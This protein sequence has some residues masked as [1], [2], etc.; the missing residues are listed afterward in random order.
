MTTHARTRPPGPPPPAKHW[1]ERTDLTLDD[2][3]DLVQAD[4]FTEYDRL[5]LI[6]G[7]LVAMSPK[8]RRHEV[9]REVLEAH[10]HDRKPAQAFVTAE[11]QLNLADTL[12]TNPDLLVRPQAIRT[13]D[14]RGADCL[15]VVE[16]S[17]TSLRKDL[18]TKAP[19]YAAHGVREYWVINAA[20][21]VTTVHLG[22]SATGYA[23]AKR[24]GRDKL[25]VP[26]LV[27]ELA[28]RLDQL[29]L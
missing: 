20:T 5:E 21:L 25:L 23:S 6:D 26:H 7:R 27:P 19:I 13:P 1:S 4:A 16:V 24:F 8:G 12:F 14:V 22:P 28:V 11:P 29:D 2:I 3:E 10:F 17:D 9:V 15:L 18:T